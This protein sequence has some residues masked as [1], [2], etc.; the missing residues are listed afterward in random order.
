[1]KKKCICLFIFHRSFCCCFFLEIIYIHYKNVLKVNPRHQDDTQNVTL[2]GLIRTTPG[3]SFTKQL[4]K[5]SG[6][7]SLSEKFTLIPYQKILSLILRYFMKLAPG[8]YC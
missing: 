1:M 3:S 8:R 7:S 6:L 2:K 4:S 5:I